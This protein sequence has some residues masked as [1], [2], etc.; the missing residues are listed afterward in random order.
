MKWSKSGDQGLIDLEHHHT[1]TLTYADS[2][3][4]GMVTCAKHIH[5]MSP[6]FSSINICFFP[7]HCP[8]HTVFWVSRMLLTQTFMWV[9]SST[10]FFS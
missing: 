10:L 1:P 6:P 7:D 5:L 9:I 8:F 3:V 2:Q 4:T